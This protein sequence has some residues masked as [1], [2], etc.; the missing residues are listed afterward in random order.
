[1]DPGQTQRDVASKTTVVESVY[2]LIKAIAAHIRDGTSQA[3]ADALEQRPRDFVDA[4]FANTPDAQMTAGAQIPP[5]SLP[6]VT[7]TG[8]SGMRAPTAEEQPPAT[9]APTLTPAQQRAAGKEAADK[10][11][12]KSSR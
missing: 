1:M 9:P 8:N 12:D 5:G 3:L 4:V 10:A 2:A 11:N 7:D 6:H